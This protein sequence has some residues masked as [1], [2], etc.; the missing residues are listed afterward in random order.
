MKTIIKTLDSNKVFE[1]YKKIAVF[2]IGYIFRRKLMKMLRKFSTFQGFIEK[3][4]LKKYIPLYVLF[5]KALYHR[6]KLGETKIQEDTAKFT[7]PK[8]FPNL[9]K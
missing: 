2:Q 5:L 4:S 7:N 1:L 6:I 8:L 3:C 9:R